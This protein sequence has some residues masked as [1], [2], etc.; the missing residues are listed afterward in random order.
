MRTKKLLKSG[1]SLAVV[2][3]PSYL[4]FIGVD[5]KRYKDYNFNISVDAV[6]KRIII[7]LCGNNTDNVL[8]GLDYTNSV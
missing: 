7:E 6:K 3:P 2:I 1:N 4:E 8:D 5:K